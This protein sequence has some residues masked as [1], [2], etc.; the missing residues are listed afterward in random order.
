MIGL[1]ADL[2]PYSSSP[3]RFWPPA[4]LPLAAKRLKAIP[5]DFGT[6]FSTI[7]QRYKKSSYL[8]CCTAFLVKG[9]VRESLT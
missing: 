9:Q 5:K 7:L 6:A 2:P 4:A 3:R 1:T 8:P